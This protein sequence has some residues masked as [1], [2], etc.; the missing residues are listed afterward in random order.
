M[1]DI[2]LIIDKNFEAFRGVV[3]SIAFKFREELVIS[4]SRITATGSLFRLRGSSEIDRTRTMWTVESSNNS[5]ARICAF[6]IGDQKT[7]II[8]Q[9]GTGYRGQ[10]CLPIGKAFDDL[11]EILKTECSVSSEPTEQL[12]QQVEEL[13]DSNKMLNVE[14]SVRNTKI[15]GLN[16][17]KKIGKNTD[18]FQKLVDETRMKND[19]PN[20][21]KIGRKLGIHHSTAKR[22]VEIHKLH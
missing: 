1:A 16:V 22:Y 11:I 18:E 8:F 17:L 2:E 7:K 6:L 21:S 12:K 10:K 14:L 19:K 20:Y 9:D 4:E 3:N 5:G 15:K 13:E